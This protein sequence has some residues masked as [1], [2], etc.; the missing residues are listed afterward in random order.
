[1]RFTC[2]DQLRSNIAAQLRFVREYARINDIRVVREFVE[3]PVSRM[4]VRCR[5]LAGMIE[6]LR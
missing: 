5:Q 1:M 2:D 4:A 6:F 3:G